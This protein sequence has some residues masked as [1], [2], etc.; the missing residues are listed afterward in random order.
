M[1]RA[2]PA[3]LILLLF[4]GCKTP[5]PS[6]RINPSDASTATVYPA[7][8]SVPAPAFKV[9]H[10][11][12]DTYTLVTKEDATGDEMFALLWEFRDAARDHTFDT[13][14][15][16]Q[17]FIDAR[18]PIVWIHVYRG[19]KC[20]SEKYT[21][22]PLPCEAAYHGAGDFTFGDYKN[23][24]WSDGVLHHADGSQTELWDP[25]KPYTK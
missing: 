12:N 18:K 9:F 19:A 21:K 25:D 7:R 15:L 22:G 4:A 16:S 11:D 23:P 10:Q 2:I 6:A 8:P 5:Q 17:K 3:L 24:Q 1:N 13:L 20:A 14:H